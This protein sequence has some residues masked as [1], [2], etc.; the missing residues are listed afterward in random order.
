[1]ALHSD[2]AVALSFSRNAVQR[3]VHSQYVNGGIKSRF[4]G[5]RPRSSSPGAPIIG[6]DLFMNEPEIVLE[7]N[8]LNR[9]AANVE[10][11]GGFMFSAPGKATK[12]C[13]VR[14]RFRVDVPLI[15][16]K[17]RRGT[18]LQVG[19]DSTKAQIKKFSSVRVGGD[20]PMPVYGI[21]PNGT[22]LQPA[23]ALALIGGDPKQFLFTPPS[24]QKLL[25]IGDGIGDLGVK[26]TQDS[27]NI[28]IDVLTKTTGNADA[29]VDL[30]R[31]HTGKGW[32]KEYREAIRIGDE[33]YGSPIYD[34]GWARSVLRPFGP[35]G[36]DVAVVVNESI[37]WDIYRQLGRAEVFRGF[38]D[39]KAKQV[40]AALDAWTRKI[41]DAS[42]IAKAI[43]EDTLEEFMTFHE[44][45]VARTELNALDFAMRDD[46]LIVDGQA[47]Y[48]A[49]TTN[50][51][52]KLRIVKTTAEG[53]TSFLE[54]F[55]SLEG[56]TGEVTEVDIDKPL[57]V[58]VVE[59]LG[60]AVG[61]LFAPFTGGASL[62]TAFLLDVLLDLVVSNVLQNAETKFGA[63]VLKAFSRDQGTL[64]F[65]LPGT[66]GPELVF[67]V[68][69]IVVKREG[70]AAWMRFGT[71][72]GRAR[73]F[74]KEYPEARKEVLWSVHNR[75]LIEVKFDDASELYHPADP[76]VR[77]RWTLFG[78]DKSR[79]IGEVD[80]VLNGPLSQIVDRK[81]FSIDHASDELD[82]FDAFIVV[83]RVYRSTGQEAEEL[84][85]EELTIRIEDRLE[86]KHRYVRWRHG[87]YYM[88]FS[89]KKKDPKRRPTDWVAANRK[90]KIHYTDP[91]KRCRFA[92]HYSAGLHKDRLDYFDD[93]PFALRDIAANRSAV[94][95]YCFFGGPDK[96]MLKF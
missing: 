13:S 15:A 83:C 50:F 57:V 78:E 80:H 9:V 74:L 66:S 41:S 51:R 10:L 21:D 96:Q 34:V 20:D 93:L 55:S 22:D 5:S 25:G 12:A 42:E 67:R 23:I 59:L 70:L 68:D 82:A 71:E 35:H 33:E 87:V 8:D 77:V 37:V 62:V 56:F 47:T 2:F 89:A 1:M 76:R 31:I 86:R 6:F 39:A 94:C 92:D 44:P 3:F 4:K 49:V 65:R 88:G 38:A 45:A 26:V 54:R 53:T 27:L 60:L 95:P 18:L 16:V 90:S 11:L 72:T 32:L 85:T 17:N 84:F 79:R 81:Q 64:R 52:L 28:G 43:R 36:T 30:N 40:R 63:G 19:L 14:V 48:E 73:I 75:A 29:L 24:L 69:D 46:R 91:D 58:D 61:V 7:P